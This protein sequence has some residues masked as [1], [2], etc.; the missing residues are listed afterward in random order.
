MKKVLAIFLAAALLLSF[1]ACAKK[2]QP[3]SQ[4][5]TE[6]QTQAQSKETP[7]GEKKILTI[8]FSWS[9]NTDAFANYI[10]DTVGGDIVRITPEKAYPENYDDVADYAKKERDDNARPAFKDLGVNPEDYDAIF[11][12]YPIW[13]YTLPMIMY[14]FFDTYDFS[15]KTLIPFNTHEGSGDGGTYKTIKELEPNATVLDGLAIRGGEI[16]GAESEV[17]EWLG[18]LEY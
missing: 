5:Q 8:Y 11:V 14:T 15:G 16:G 3:T 7:Q 4:A 9:G 17:K 6:A 18:K 10:H 1:A 13:W 12:G 2:D